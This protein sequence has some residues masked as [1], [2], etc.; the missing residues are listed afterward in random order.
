MFGLPPN[1]EHSWQLAECERINAQLR[2]LQLS[3]HQSAKFDREHWSTQ[4]APLLNLWKRLNK[5]NSYCILFFTFVFKDSGANIL[6]QTSDGNVRQHVDDDPIRA[7][8][9]LERCVV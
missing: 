5:V 9:A 8:V 7:F 3:D 6:E 2:Q 1:I 4:L